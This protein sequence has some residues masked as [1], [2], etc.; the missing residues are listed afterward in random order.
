MNHNGIHSGMRPTGRRARGSAMIEF[1]LCIPFLASLLGMTFFF[2]WAM[3]NKQNVEVSGRYNTWR[4]MG[5]RTTADGGEVNANILMGR[6]SAVDLSREV[7]PAWLAETRKTQ[8]DLVTATAGVSPQAGDL[9]NT[10]INQT[11]HPEYGQTINSDF[12]TD[13]GA[14]KWANLAGPMTDWYIREGGVWR[15]GEAREGV[16]LR[17]CPPSDALCDL[18]L[19][20]LE[21]AMTGVR[22]PG[23]G[24]A[25]M[26]RRLYV[27]GW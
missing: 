7:P 13:I 11:L 22:A 21:S 20:P 26:T 19:Q 27:H 1:V 14:A 23:T 9:A 12:P 24:L 10:L 16:S 5:T 18:F 4:Y 25:D 15:R 17:D 3:Q 6:S 2:G 8:Q